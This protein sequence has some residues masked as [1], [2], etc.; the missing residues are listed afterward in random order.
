MKNIIILFT[1]SLLALNQMVVFA[2]PGNQ[3]RDKEHQERWE[4]YRSEKIAFLTTNLDLSPEEAQK[5]WP[6]YNEMDKEKSEAQMRRRELEQK[7]HNAEASLSDKQI[8]KLTREYAGNMEQE[9]ALSTKYNEKFLSIL[10]PQKVLKLYQVE[11]DF[12]MYMFKKYRDQRK[13][14]N[15]HP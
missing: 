6:I 11:N 4:K 12:R 8:I 5:F 7:V 10:P 2:Q 9:G 13:K 15:E 14:E 1:I 3:G